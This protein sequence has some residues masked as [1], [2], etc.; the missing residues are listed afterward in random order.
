MLKIYFEKTKERK[1][2]AEKMY[3][4][5]YKNGICT[6]K[7]NCTGNINKGYHSS[8]ALQIGENYD[9][10]IDGRPIRILFMGKESPA[11]KSTK[12][13]PRTAT[14]MEVAEDWAASHNGRKRVNL[15]YQETYK[16]LCYMLNYNPE[17]IYPFYNRD[18]KVLKHFALTNRYRC[19]LDNGRT[20]I[21]NNHEQRK[22]CLC[23]LREELRIMKPTVI[24]LQ[25]Q[26]TT[27]DELFFD[28]E[29]RTEKLKRDEN[30]ERVV[31]SP[32]Y[33]CYVIE[34][35]HPNTRGA[36]WKHKPK[37]LKSVDYLKYKGVLPDLS[38][39]LTD[40]INKK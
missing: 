40:E 36:W 23:I 16:M 1:N 4:D 26:E 31:Y 10:D 13:V 14:L 18:D 28:D 35:I 7:K 32:K 8:Y 34:T 39:D 25:L 9:F 2:L 12:N 29:N 15:H 33:D 20:N 11:D 17:P 5:Y 21:T 27:A 3:S 30:T 37:F 22:N 6:F 38:V 19:K 24:V